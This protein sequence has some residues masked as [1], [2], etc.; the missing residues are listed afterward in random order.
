[1]N[2]P[3]NASAF[4]EEFGTIA[5]MPLPAGW[6]PAPQK[7]RKETDIAT[8]VKFTEPH[9]PDIQIC[10]H[11]RGTPISD[12]QAENFRG[13]L[14][15]DPHILHGDEWWSIHQV[16]NRMALSDEFTIASVH[17]ENLNDRK[18]LVSEGRWK[19]S[20]YNMYSVF[21]DADGSGS[22]IEE[23]YYAAPKSDY[24]MFLTVASQAIKSVEWAKTSEENAD[25]AIVSERNG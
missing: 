11:I 25:R 24:F 1:M 14:A 22:V 5:R 2:P 17:T 18:V 23:I 10:F 3:T 13:V 12:A 19:D 7:S 6:L 21:I 16:L 15:K 4:I 9:N 8:L 20:D